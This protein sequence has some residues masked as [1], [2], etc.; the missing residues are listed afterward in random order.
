MPKF[1]EMEV[2]QYFG[3]LLVPHFPVSHI[4]TQIHPSQYNFHTIQPISS[5]RMD[6]CALYPTKFYK[7]AFISIKRSP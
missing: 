1:A 2:N 3:R 4:T 7:Y 6:T 5:F